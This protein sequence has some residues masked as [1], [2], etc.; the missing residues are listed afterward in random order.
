MIKKPDLRK[1]TH[2]D[3]KS[4]NYIAADSFEKITWIFERASENSLEQLTG[5]SG[6]D[7]WKR[8]YWSDFF[9]SRVLFDVQAQ[10]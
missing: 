3:N 8:Q 4:T 1:A 7:P 10:H 2:I 9:I 5:S 6:R